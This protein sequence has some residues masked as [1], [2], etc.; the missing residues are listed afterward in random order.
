MNKLIQVLFILLMPVM[1]LAAEEK[2][3][4]KQNWERMQTCAAQAE[5]AGGDNLQRNHYSAKYERCFMLLR[6]VGHDRD[7]GYVSWSL[8]D[9]FEGTELAV[10]V[11]NT[12]GPPE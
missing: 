9:A 11:I 4:D 3:A 12:N 6:F 5:K 10:I 8:V 2:P 1:G 7:S